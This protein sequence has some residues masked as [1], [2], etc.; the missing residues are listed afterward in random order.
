MSRQALHMRNKLNVALGLT[1]LQYKAQ[2]EKKIQILFPV[3][4]Q[5]LML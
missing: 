5:W 2:Q 3:P 4:T 1:H